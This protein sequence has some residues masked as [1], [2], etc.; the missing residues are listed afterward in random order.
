MIP[1][2]KIKKMIEGL[3]EYVVQ[4]FKNTPDEKDTFL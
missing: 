4:D 1:I 2:V 3:L